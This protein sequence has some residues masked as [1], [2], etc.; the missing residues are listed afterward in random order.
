MKKSVPNIIS[1]SRLVLS[2][3]LL[4][5]MDW[6]PLFVSL[7]FIIG[8]SDVTDGFIARRY[9]LATQF[10]ARLDSAADIVFYL[11]IVAVLILKYSWIITGNKFLLAVILILKLSTTV[12][13]WIK[14]G[15]VTFIHSIANKIT[16][17]LI[18]CSCVVIPLVENIYLAK[19]VFLVA[20]YAA[21]EE[22]CIIISCKEIDLNRRSLFRK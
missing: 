18:F 11:V 10:G 6:R 4:L 16:G 19:G 17:S 3:V 1:A 8:L 7:V 14:F 9:N 20:V 2:L 12:I 5:I 22:F 21:A 13:S 15:K